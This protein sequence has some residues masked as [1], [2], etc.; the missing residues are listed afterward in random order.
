MR[1]LLPLL[2]LGAAPVATERQ[3]LADAKREAAAA[4]LRADQLAAAAAREGDAAARAR[5][6][7]AALGTRVRAAAARVRAAE[8]RVALVAQAQDAVRARLAEEQ[9]PAA[10]L[11]A[12]LT[13]LARRPT[14]AAVAQPGSVDDLVHVRAV[15]GAQL[16]VVRQRAAGVR[17]EL[18]A[19]R[20]LQASA[21]LAVQALRDG[22]AQLENSRV[23]LAQLEAR[24]RGQASAY[25][26]GAMAESDRALALGE[27]ARDL[28][29]RLSEEGRA[30][31]TVA[32]LENLPGPLPRPLTPGPAP[33]R[34]G[35]GAYRLPVAG[36]VVTGLGE[37]SD[38]GVRSRGLTFRVAP[39]AFVVAPAAGVVRY[40]RPFRGYGMIVVIDHGDG[41]TSLLTG[42]VQAAVRA[43]QRVAAGAPVGRA[44]R[45]EEPLVTVELR[46]RGRPADIAAL[47][48]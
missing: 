28:V 32:E 11:L 17:A 3:R 36:A 40:A 42:L 21:E 18:A 13:G 29:D 9:A 34:S 46:R 47:I 43:G 38:A 1:R 25:G 10:R 37:V 24:H 20:R 39:G 41:W 35:G 45:A 12:A 14:I 48:G 33:A 6:E 5:A 44:A 19:A 22:R 4:S 27:R 7:E 31:T 30:R 2:L 15:L 23:A 26:E 8:A 16:P